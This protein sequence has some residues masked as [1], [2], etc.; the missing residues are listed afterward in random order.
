MPSIMDEPYLQTKGQGLVIRA[1]AKVSVLGL[2]LLFTL[3]TVLCYLRLIAM[4]LPFTRPA[5]VAGMT[6]KEWS[7]Y[8][9]PRGVL[10]SVGAEGVW[11]EFVKNVL[12]P[13]FSA[14]CTASED[15]VMEHPVEE[16]LGVYNFHHSYNPYRLPC[17]Y[18]IMSG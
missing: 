14:V 6:F 9:E 3:Q 10:A 18:K 11:R 1:A 2:F 8:S 17:V 16:F 4:A 15:D 7:Q 13:L 5:D 12:V